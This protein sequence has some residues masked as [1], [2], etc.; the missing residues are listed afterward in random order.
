[1]DKTKIIIGLLFGLIA[2]LGIL[3]VLRQPPDFWMTADQQGEGLMQKGKFA[4]AAERFEDPLR[5]GEA[6]YRDGQFEEAAG[7]FA[8]ID[9]ERAAYNRGNALIMLG[10]YDEAIDSFDRATEFEPEWKEAKENRELAVARRDKLKPPDDDAGG[11]GGMLGAD[12]IVF[13]NRAQNSSETQEIE[14]GAGDQLSDESLRALWLQRVQTNPA[15][16]LRVRFSY[17]LA[18]REAE[19]S[20]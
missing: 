1:M 7:Y 19:K 8:R 17:Q 14:V 20:E 15:D 9:N 16:F 11:T 12:E 10:K 4:D 13:D 5:K 18:R 3:A 6:L 2:V